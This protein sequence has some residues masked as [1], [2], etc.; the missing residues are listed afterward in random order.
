MVKKGVQPLPLTSI[1][2]T[3][4]RPSKKMAMRSARQERFLMG[5]NAMTI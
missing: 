5:D 2:P 3:V 1:T 4:D